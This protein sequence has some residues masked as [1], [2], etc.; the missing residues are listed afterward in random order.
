MSKIFTNPNI[1]ALDDEMH[2][3]RIEEEFGLLTRVATNMVRFAVWT[4]LCQQGVTE[5][6]E[7]DVE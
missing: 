7:A 2:K 4:A 1:D 5:I 6:I 3:W